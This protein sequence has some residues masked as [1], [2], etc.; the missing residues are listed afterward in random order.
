M[1]RRLVHRGPD[2]QGILR[3]PDRLAVLGHCRLAI[4]DPAGGDQPIRSV[5]LHSGTVGGQ[6]LKIYRRKGYGEKI[7]N[8]YRLR[9]IQK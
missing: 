4:M 3:D 9:E 5:V 7:A 1:M 2:S 8:R 6:G